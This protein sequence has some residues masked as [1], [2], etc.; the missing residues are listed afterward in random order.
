MNIIKI[1]VIIAIVGVGAYL[2]LSGGKVNFTGNGFNI[3]KTSETYTGTIKAAVEK[4]I[5]LKCTAP[6]DETTGIEVVAGYIKGK[7]YYGEIIQKGEPGYIIMTGN[8]MYSW[9]KGASQGAKMCFSG[10]IWEQQG[11]SNANYSC[12]GAVIPDSMFTP[13]SDVTFLEV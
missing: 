1:V 6:K 10:D 3:S 7:N 9:K 13:P 5:P 4:G 8:C 11:S 2:L 12:K